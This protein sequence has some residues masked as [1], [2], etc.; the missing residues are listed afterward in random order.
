MHRRPR[1]PSLG[2]SSRIAAVTALVLVLT[3]TTSVLAVANLFSRSG[4]FTGCLG[5]H[6]GSIYNVAQSATTPLD[7]CASGDHAITFGNSG[8]LGPGGSAGPN[9]QQLAILRWYPANQIG[10][11]YP[12][13][14]LPVGIAFDGTNLWVANEGAATVTKLRSADGSLVGT[15]PVG[16]K[17]VAIAYDGAS[18][19]VANSGSDNVSRLHAADG[20]LV[21]T[22]PAGTIP[23]AIAFDGA[24][25]WLTDGGDGTSPSVVTELR[26]S[27]GALVRTAAVGISPSGIAFDGTNLWV[28]NTGS[29]DLTE[30]RASDGTLIGTYPDVPGG[31]PRAVAFDGSSIWLANQGSN[32][33]TAFRA[34]D[35]ARLADIPLGT[36]CCA[37]PWALAFDGAN[38][39]VAA[40][41]AI[42]KLRISDGT[43]LGRYAHPNAGPAGAAFDGVNIWVV[44]NALG[45]ISKF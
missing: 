40:D 34:S 21:G 37:G 41:P 5:N 11:S 9:P 13:G 38:L 19:W 36:A 25:I 44:N 33:I 32:S 3:V 18:I 43:I 7:E 22:Y 30:V 26:A 35:G 20:S 39:W 10:Q 31:F 45:S 12:V 29:N 16:V 14:N 6:S 23:T 1:G 24:N 4:P 2:R 28:A 8:Q 17:P 15:Y 27:D 42:V